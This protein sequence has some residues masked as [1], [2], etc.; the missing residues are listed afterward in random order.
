MVSYVFQELEIMAIFKNLDDSQQDPTWEGLSSFHP[1][2]RSTTVAAALLRL[3]K[4]WPGC[5]DPEARYLLDYSEP[6]W[7][8]VTTTN[9]TTL[10]AAESC[11]TGRVV[12]MV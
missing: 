2:P 10:R 4:Q 8:I 3:F 7:Q 9:G 5:S 11:I 12:L 1:F 6:D